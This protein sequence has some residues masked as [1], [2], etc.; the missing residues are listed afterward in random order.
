MSFSFLPQL[1]SRYGHLNF[2][3]FPKRSTIYRSISPSSMRIASRRYPTGRSGE[4]HPA[5]PLRGMSASAWGGRAAS[6]TFGEV[7]PPHTAYGYSNA[8]SPKG[9]PTPRILRAKNSRDGWE[10]G[11]GERT[12][13]RK[14]DPCEDDLARLL[15]DFDRL[16]GVSAH[17]S[18]LTFDREKK[19]GGSRATFTFYILY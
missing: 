9:G 17:P 6:A 12:V 1:F 10:C 11:E 19:V 7:H 16:R 4:D 8:L 13:L 3:L 14:L 5:P 15:V 2:L 18:N